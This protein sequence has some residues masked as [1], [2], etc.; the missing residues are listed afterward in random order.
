[1]LLLCSWTE[2]VFSSQTHTVG[3]KWI[4]E[5][6]LK[7]GVWYPSISV[8]EDTRLGP[9]DVTLAMDGKPTKQGL[10]QVILLSHGNSGRVRNHHLTAKALVRGGFIVIAPLHTADHLLA[11]ENIA[12][13]LEWR[14]TELRY[15]LE[16]VLQERE[17][18]DRIDLSHVHAIGYSLGALTAFNA[19]GAVIDV[20]A[21]DRHCVQEHDPEFC[22]NP[23]FFLR[24]W[25][26]YL[27]EVKTPDLNRKIPSL[28]FPFGFVNGSIAV[29]APVGQGVG[30]NPNSF[31]AKHI[32]VI[33]LKQDTVT[34]PQFHAS[35]LNTLFSKHVETKYELVDGH[36]EAFIA[37]FAK[38][39]TDVEHIPAAIDPE[40]FDRLAFLNSINS[41]LV[42]FFI[43]SKNK[44]SSA[45]KDET[46]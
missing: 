38:R 2:I 27:R 4:V 12:K 18:R 33:G 31:L 20:A 13:V 1:M 25:T 3:F 8:E 35:N 32:L 34:L 11:G 21:A 17:F 16:A 5:N 28:Y 19:A 7:I 41:R 43:Q 22:E 44:V 42:N 46:K 14:V 40:G 6:D 30:I 26:K 15:A 23:S 37:P 29:V 36:H 45:P 39:V 10:Y 24:W 9:F